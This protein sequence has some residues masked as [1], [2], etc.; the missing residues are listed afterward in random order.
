MQHFLS[1]LPE[2]IRVYLKARLPGGVFISGKSG[3]DNNGNFCFMV[4]VLKG[5]LYHHLKFDK[6][7]QFMSEEMEPAFE[8]GYSEQYY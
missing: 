3:K 5:D 8:E 4:H 7:G 6:A 2:N 1:S